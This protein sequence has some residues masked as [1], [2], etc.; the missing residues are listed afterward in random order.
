[1]P[2]EDKKTP[3]N[4]VVELIEKQFEKDGWTAYTPDSYASGLWRLSDEEIIEH[5]RDKGL[6]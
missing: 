6:I 5:L 4:S 2:D 1:M 3:C